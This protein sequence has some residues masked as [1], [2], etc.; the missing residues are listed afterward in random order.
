MRTLA[1][2]VVAVT[3]AFT[4]TTPVQAVPFVY[5]ANQYSGDVSQYEVGESGL[6]APLLPAAVGAGDLPSAVAI[7]PDGRSVYVTNQAGGVSQYDV[8]AGGRLFP[9]SPAT[10]D[11]GV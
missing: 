3:L 10:V 4:S 11:A 6:L 8:G 2:A 1:L 5:V 7:R 9:K